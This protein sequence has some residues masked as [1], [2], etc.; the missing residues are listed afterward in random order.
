M[1]DLGTGP[2][3]KHA[4]QI[5]HDQEEYSPIKKEHY[6]SDAAWMEG[7]SL[8]IGMYGKLQIKVYGIVSTYTNN[9]KY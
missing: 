6:F 2:G 1:W 4:V 8:N 9:Y 3:I 5:Q 7:L